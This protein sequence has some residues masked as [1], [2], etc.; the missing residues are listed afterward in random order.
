M[1]KLKLHFLFVLAVFSKKVEIDTGCELTWEE[2]EKTNIKG[3]FQTGY[4]KEQCVLSPA[5]AFAE[6]CGS[7]PRML[8][9]WAGRRKHLSVGCFLPLF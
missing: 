2:E 6:L 1:T 4:H 5:G 8:Y 7:C 9:L 3:H